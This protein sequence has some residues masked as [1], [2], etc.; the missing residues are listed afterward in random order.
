M[1]SKRVLLGVAVVAVIAIGYFAITGW[2][3]TEEGAEGTIGA[4]DR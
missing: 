1:S 2:P 3:P 4:A